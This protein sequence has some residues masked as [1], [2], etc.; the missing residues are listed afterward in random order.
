MGQR[1][2]VTKLATGLLRL[3]DCQVV[4]SDE[5]IDAGS[6]LIEDGI[7]RAIDPVSVP[8]GAQEIDLEGNILMPGLI[9]LHSDAIEHEVE[10]RRGSRLPFDLAVRQADRLFATVGV[11]TA[12]H[13]LSFMG[14][15]ESSRTNEFTREF[16]E[17]VSKLRGHAIIDNR[18]HA[19]YEITNAEGLAHIQELVE[20]RIV[21]MVSIMDHTPG[22]GQ[23]PDAESFREYCRSTGM[24]DAEIDRFL[25]NKKEASEKAGPSVEALAETVRR[26]GLPFASH[27][28]DLPERIPYFHSLG[29]TIAEFPM[30]LP[31]AR[32]AREHDLTVLV[33]AP[34]LLRGMSSGQGPRAMD[35]IDQGGA[36]ALCSDYMPATILPAIFKVVNELDFPLWKAVSLGTINPAEG[37]RLDDRGEIAVGKRADLIEVEHHF[38]WPIVRKLWTA[39][40]MTYSSTPLP[41]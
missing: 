35:L 25:E 7:I 20:N 13:S 11:T 19:R 12:F 36:N 22:Q 30:N 38:G 41:T 9:D 27:D 8:V 4:L 26:H 5:V 17:A 16:A 21:S 39:G 1:S 18:V 33:G 14:G 31:S 29:V 10:P 15:K 32:A 3:V 40:R 28:D 24:A 6:V 34:N 23:Y 37:A 2:D